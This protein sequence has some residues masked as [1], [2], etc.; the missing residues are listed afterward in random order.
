MPIRP[1]AELTPE[2]REHLA[3]Q[4][5][6]VTVSDAYGEQPYVSPFA[7]EPDGITD[8]SLFDA[9]EYVEPSTDPFDSVYAPSETPDTVKSGDIVDAEIVKDKPLINPDKP[10]KAKPSAG[11]PKLDE[12]LD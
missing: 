10:V 5:V 6:D 2:A 9:P 8:T 11:P 4:G 12:W 3:N 1:Q 7:A